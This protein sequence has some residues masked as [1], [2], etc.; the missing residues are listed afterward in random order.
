MVAYCRRTNRKEGADEAQTVEMIGLGIWARDVG[1]PCARGISASPASTR[2]APARPS[3]YAQG[4]SRREARAKSHGA[5]RSSSLPFLR[6]SLGSRRRARRACDFARLRAATPLRVHA[7][8]RRR[9]ATS[10]PATRIRARKVRRH[11]RA[12]YSEADLSH[13]LRLIAPSF[14]VGPPANTLP[15]S[16]KKEAEW[17]PA[18]NLLVG[19]DI[20]GTF[21]DCVA[22]DRA[23]RITATNGA[24]TPGNFAKACSRRLRRRPSGRLQFEE[25]CG[26]SRW[27]P[28]ATSTTRSSREKARAS[29]LIKTRGTRTRSIM[30]GLARRFLARPSPGWSL[31]LEPEAGGPIVA[32]APDRRLSERV[33]C[34]GEVVVPLNESRPSP[35]SAWS[36]PASRRSASVFSG[37]SSIRGRAAREGDDS[38]DRADLFA[39]ARPNRAKGASTRRHRAALNAYIGPVMAK[40]LGNLAGH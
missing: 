35:R 13:R 36:K 19:V 24:S 32:Q 17:R 34:F 3:M 23:G 21:T 5:P 10:K 26:E 7:R 20:G 22:L 4:R 11:R 25:F 8:A 29:G 39:P 9:G 14:S 16:L 40:Y 1:E 6:P 18:S 33:D 31:S 28:T 30:R 27:S 15:F 38:E 12:H 37:R 2:A